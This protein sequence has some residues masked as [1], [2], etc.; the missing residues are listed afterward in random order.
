MTTKKQAGIV[1]G[2]LLL[3]IVIVGAIAWFIFDAFF[4]DAEKKLAAKHAELCRKHAGTRITRTVEGVDGYYLI[5]RGTNLRAVARAAKGDEQAAGRPFWEGQCTEECLRSLVLDGYRF[6]EKSEQ[7]LPENAT[8]PVSGI[9]RYRLA[10][11]GSASCVDID[12]DQVNEP[13]ARRALDLMTQRGQCLARTRIAKVSAKYQV[14]RNIDIANVQV[15]GVIMRFRTRIRERAK[16]GT[17]ADQT[18]YMPLASRNFR[19][20]REMQCRTQSG[21]PV[22]HMLD[23]REVLRPSK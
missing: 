11:A 20:M 23:A 5:V 9:Y 13:E 1:A 21:K 19:W 4:G 22:A 7:T 15:G 6:I 18:I 3:L 12:P 16:A 10:N 17:L 14:R 2:S 8:V